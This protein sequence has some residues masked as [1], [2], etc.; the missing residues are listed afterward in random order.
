[1]VCLLLIDRSLSR[2]YRWCCRQFRV[3]AKFTDTCDFYWRL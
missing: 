2:Q 1:M 3:G